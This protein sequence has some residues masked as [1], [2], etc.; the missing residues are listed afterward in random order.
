MITMNL[1]RLG[2]RET[3]LRIWRVTLFREDKTFS[4]LHSNKGIQRPTLD[5]VL[6]VLRASCRILDHGSF[7]VWAQSEG[8]DQSRRSEIVYL[9]ALRNALRFSDFLGDDFFD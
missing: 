2:Q 3:D 5:Q 9:S 1:R 7:G 6:G 4:C 8:Y